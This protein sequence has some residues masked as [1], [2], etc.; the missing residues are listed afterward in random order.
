ENS[1]SKKRVRR[2]DEPTATTCL[3]LRGTGDTGKK[4]ARFCSALWLLLNAEPEASP[5]ATR[6]DPTWRLSR[7]HATRLGA[8]RRGVAL[9]CDDAECSSA[10]RLLGRLDCVGEILQRGR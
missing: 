5:S 2:K 6:Q 3:T 7:P 10:R 8:S 4:G 1:S 9:T